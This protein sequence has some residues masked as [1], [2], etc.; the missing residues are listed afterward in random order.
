ML[1]ATD[2][3]VDRLRADPRRIQQVVDVLPGGYATTSLAR[4]FDGSGSGAPSW[5]SLVQQPGSDQVTVTAERTTALPAFTNGSYLPYYLGQDLLDSAGEVVP[6]PPGTWTWSMAIPDSWGFMI[7]GPPELQSAHAVRIEFPWQPPAASVQ[8]VFHV[9]SAEDWGDGVDAVLGI[10]A[11]VSLLAV[12]AS[13]AAVFLGLARDGAAPTRR[14]A[15]TRGVTTGAALLVVPVVAVLAWDISV[16]RWDQLYWVQDS[17]WHSV[18]QVSAEGQLIETQVQGALLG[19]FLFSLP[20]FAICALRAA[21]GAGPPPPR[22]VVAL[23]LPALCLLVTAWLM[24][25]GLWNGAVALCCGAASVAAGAV[26]LAPRLHSAAAAVR[27]WLP[28][29]AAAAWTTVVA[30]I[31]LDAVPA[32]FR[33]SALA[34]DPAT[35]LD[36]RAAIASWLLVYLLLTPLAT[37]LLLL[38]GGLPGLA[39]PVVSQLPR[40]AR[41]ALVPVLVTALLP[42]WTGTEDPSYAHPRSIPLIT[43]LTGQTPGSEYIAGIDVLAPTLQVVWLAATVLLLTQLRNSGGSPGRWGASA[44]AG[45]V[46]LVLLAAAAPFAGS[47]KTWLPHTT[48]AAALAAVWCGSLVLLP[49]ERRAR[50]TRLHALSGAAHARLVNS[51]ARALLFSES[52]HR[53]LSASRGTLADSSA[54]PQDWERTWQNLRRPTG[55]DAARE[56]ALLRATALGSS[57]GRSAWSNGL[58]AAGAGGLLTLPWTAWPAWHGLGFSGLPEVLTIAGGTT[59]VWLAHGFL[60]GYLY[61]WLRGRGPVAKAG[62]LWAVMSPVQILLLWPRL[63]PPFSQTALSVTLLLAQST[64]LALGLAL[65]WEIRL[66]RRADLLWGHV[67][68]FRRLSSLAAPLSAVLVAAIAAAVTVLASTWAGE[69]TAPDVPPTPAT[70]PAVPGKP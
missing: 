53:F 19:V 64:V 37:A 42:W 6:R 67:R 51:L 34:A 70:S 23:T 41:A 62:W 9:R 58:A 50:A 25:G 16:G 52:R 20:L 5:C 8:A 54:S 57:A 24:G 55:S 30:T 66:V 43:Q 28:A 1:R 2:P 56:T 11:A 49:S 46:A 60:Y 47:P 32:Q 59:L 33:L 13:V 14:P 29:L 69:L 18:G 21:R 31:V 44:R 40:W 35:A 17:G 4:T 45:C 39:L 63:Q 26:L 12:L 36:H 10:K 61:P 38:V 22:H 7:N 48:S 27:T 68:N 15:L 65:F 3:L